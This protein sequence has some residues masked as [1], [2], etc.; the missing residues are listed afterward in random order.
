MIQAMFRFSKD[1]GFTWSNSRIVDIGKLGE[2]DT[3][4]QFRKLGIGRDWV[5]ELSVTDPVKTVIVN[6]TVGTPDD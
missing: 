4:V 3:G 2:Y 6:A 1:G 5:F